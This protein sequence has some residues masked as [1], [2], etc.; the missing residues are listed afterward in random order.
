MATY[1]VSTPTSSTVQPAHFII[2][3]LQLLTEITRLGTDPQFVC[4]TK[5][6]GAVDISAS[7][8]IVTGT[9]NSSDIESEDE[10]EVTEGQSLNTS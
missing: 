1:L 3:C 5:A 6:S 4:A 2:C 10:E 7:A 9:Q 8:T